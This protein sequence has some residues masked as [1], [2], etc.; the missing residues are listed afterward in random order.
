MA[1]L[2]ERVEQLIR[3]DGQALGV[4]RTI[5]DTMRAL[6]GRLARPAGGSGAPG[7]GGGGSVFGGMLG[8]VGRVTRSL[9]M[10]GFA[11][12]GVMGAFGALQGSIMAIPNAVA[13]IVR[14][15]AS[16]VQALN[17]QLV[18][19]YEARLRDLT[20]TLGYALVPVV[21]YATR[22]VREFAGVLLPAVRMFRPIVEQLSH[23]FAGLASGGVR[24]V[25]RVMERF[26]VLLGQA[27]GGIA[28]L[29][30]SW[31]AM[32][33][34][35]ASAIEVLGA[36]QATFGLISTL[37]DAN[38]SAVR[39]MT[40]AVA[41]ATARL[42]GFIGGADALKKFRESLARGLADR[43]K[44]PTGLL[45]APTDSSVTG[46]EEIA[47]KIAER[48]FI[49][50]AGAETDPP[51]V[52]LLKEIRDAVGEVKPT[53]WEE[54]ITRAVRAALPGVPVPDGAVG[55]AVR[56]LITGDSPS[57]TGRA[58]SGGLRGALLDNP[59]SP[60]FSFR[61]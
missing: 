27:T 38:A 58:A 42:I 46:F 32:L 17:P 54:M 16:Y 60:L 50:G 48:A 47:K 12:N 56:P 11:V 29:I 24:I 13:G 57:T 8:A 43:L 6:A 49:A 53:D 14:Q 51:D 39:R 36:F 30:T 45:A 25:A 28:N 55:G 19:N 33:E 23:A 59:F 18:Q 10:V 31:S 61:I 1:T 15:A 34:V 35:I 2:Q 7:A 41:V 3:L 26:A 44:P 21:A 20:A 22:S 40:V 52:A 4:L 37:F 5:N 9:G